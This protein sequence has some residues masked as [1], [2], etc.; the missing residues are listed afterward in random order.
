MIDK[1]VASLEVAVADIVDGASIMIGGFGSAGMPTELI[2]A[3][4]R[5]GS[6]DLTIVSNNAGNGEPGLTALRAARRVRKMIC[7]F[8]RQADSHRFDAHAL[9]W[10]CTWLT[11]T[12]ETRLYL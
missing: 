1:I 8:P 12:H 7:S 4:L 3:L 5:Q 11:G 6:R 10:A 2:D 9:R